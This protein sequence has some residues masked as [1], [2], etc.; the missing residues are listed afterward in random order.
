MSSS[1][2][3]VPRNSTLLQTLKET[4]IVMV[5]SEGHDLTDRQRAV[6]MIVYLEVPPNGHTV[7]ALAERLNVAKPAITRALDRLTE[8]GL[9]A[10]RPDPLDRRSVLVKTVAGGAAY[11]RGLDKTLTA[12]H[13]KA[14]AEVETEAAA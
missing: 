11:I 6:L 8:L 14:K 1:T 2:T 4:T 3:A 10:R 9:L 7:R 5:A 13:A 12:A